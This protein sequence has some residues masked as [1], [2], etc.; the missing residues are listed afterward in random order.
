MMKTTT[1][2]FGVMTVC[3]LGP[4]CKKKQS[5]SPP[6]TIQQYGV[7]VDLPKLDTAFPNAS[8]GVQAAVM[9]VKNAYQRGQLPRMIME[10]DK[11]GNNPSLS[12]PQKKL[13]NDLIEQMRQ[14]IAKSTSPA[15]Q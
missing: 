2:V 4:G 5:P 11:L 3:L 9:Q 12:E 7:A 10:L 6:G 13:V 1:L 8:P 15:G 14:V